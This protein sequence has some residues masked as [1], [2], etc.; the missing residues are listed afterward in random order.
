MI[1]QVFQAAHVPWTFTIVSDRRFGFLA[2]SLHPSDLD[3]CLPLRTILQSRTMHPLCMS[4]RRSN[5]LLSTAV[6]VLVVWVALHQWKT[7]GNQRVRLGHAISRLHFPRPSAD[8]IKWTV[9]TL[10]PTTAFRSL[11]VGIWKPFSKQFYARG[12]LERT[13]TFTINH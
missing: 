13:A 4:S 9:L 5:A 7:V 6:L 10:H 1:F 11:H 3:P 8:S 2:S 12:E